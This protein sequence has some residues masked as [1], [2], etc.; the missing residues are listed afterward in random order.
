MNSLER[1][2]AVPGPPGASHQ[3]NNSS[4]STN[5]A[6][7]AN[8]DKEEPRSSECTSDDD[9]DDFQVELATN[10]RQSFTS[11]EKAPTRHYSFL[12]EST[13]LISH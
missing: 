10:L 4:V 6:P 9:E 1:G 3:R 7:A 12:A 11:T 13:Y 8:H 2:L 5:S